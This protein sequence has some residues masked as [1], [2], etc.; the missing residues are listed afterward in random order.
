MIDGTATNLDDEG[1]IRVMKTMPRSQPTK[2]LP[3]FLPTLLELTSEMTTALRTVLR[4]LAGLAHPVDRMVAASPAPYARIVA[5]VGLAPIID[6]LSV[7]SMP[8]RGTD[9]AE[10]GLLSGPHSLALSPRFLTKPRLLTRL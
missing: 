2:A 5:L 6:A 8:P 4:P 10:I 3:P 7:I 1:R 9:P